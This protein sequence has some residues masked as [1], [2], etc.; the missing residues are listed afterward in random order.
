MA[1]IITS[2]LACWKGT[3]RTMVDSIER[4]M[5][6]HWG[7]SFDNS[8]REG[9][10]SMVSNDGTPIIPKVDCATAKPASAGTAKHDKHLK[11]T[12]DNRIAITEV[13]NA[14]IEA[15]T[16]ILSRRCNVPIDLAEDH[17]RNML[18]AICWIFVEYEESIDREWRK[19]INSLVEHL[20]DKWLH[21]SKTK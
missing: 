9:S 10:H 19:R 5:P 11:Y 6:R 2:M 7:S 8:N 14:I 15:L 17:V 13:Y 18:Q 12:H 4:T 3:R 20:Q 21:E 1:T 16:P